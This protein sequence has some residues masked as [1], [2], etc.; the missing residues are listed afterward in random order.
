M[1]DSYNQLQVLLRQNGYS[2]T[3]PRKIVFESM[4]HAE[5]RTMHEII[6]VCRHKANRASVY[7][8]IKLFETLGVVQRLHVGWK[9][10]LELSDAFAAHH[11]HLTCLGCGAV[12]DIE[13]EKHIDEFIRQ[14]SA[15]FGFTPRRHQFEIA[16]YCMSCKEGLNSNDFEK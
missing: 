16:G 12:I 9:Y 6:Q 15:K 4:Q 11:H 5:P 14:V 2:L 8:T 10:K 13:D 1:H 7:R 3:E